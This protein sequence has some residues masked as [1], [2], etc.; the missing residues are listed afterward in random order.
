MTA[1]TNSNQALGANPV[2][3]LLDLPDE[4]VHAALAS[5]DWDLT[6]ART[7][8][9]THGVHSYPAKF[10]PQLPARIIGALSEPGDLVVDPFA[11]GGTTGVEAM[12]LGRRFVGVDANPV[13][14]LL[15]NVKTTPLTRFDLDEVEAIAADATALVHKQLRRRGDQVPA[16]PNLE[17][18]Y[19]PQVVTCLSMLR[20]L[21]S[22]TPEGAARN[23]AFAAFANT[24]ARMSYQESETRYVSKPRHIDGRAPIHSFTA[25]LDRMVAR[26]RSLDGLPADGLNF[27]VGDARQREDFPLSCGSAGLV[28]TSPPYPNAYDYHLYH[29]F[30]IF[31][32]GADPKNLRRVE[33]GS[34]LKHQTDVD[35]PA[36]Y[37]AD[38]A[39]VLE[40]VHE[41]LQPGRYA[42]FVV[43]DGIYKGETYR[44]AERLSEIAISHGWKALSPITRR[45]PATRRAVTAAGRRLQT[46]EIVLLR[47]PTRPTWALPIE[48]NYKRFPYELDLARRELLALTGMDLAG[49]HTPD[50]SEAAVSGLTAAVAQSAFWHGID[51]DGLGPTAT[52]QRLLEDPTGGKRKNSTYATHGLHRYKGKF[53]P[54]LA[55]ALINLSSI[56]HPSPLLLDPFGGSGTVMLESVLSGRDAWSIDCSPLATAVAQTKVDILQVPP[57]ELM[58][59]VQAWID[60]LTTLDARAAIEWNQFKEATHDELESWFAPAVLAKLS[61]LLKSLREA[62]DTR[63]IAFGEVLVSDLIR[64]V[65]HQDPRD[66][67]IRRRSDPLDDA[68]VLELFIERLKSASFKIAAYHSI[69]STL[70]PPLGSGR[71]VLGTSASSDAY[72]ELNRRIDCVVSSP[73]YATALPYIDTDRLSLAAVYGYDKGARKFLEQR[74]IG[75]RE[76]TRA[77]Q[78]EMEELIRTG[79]TDELPPSTASFL[80]ELLDA[81]QRDN[82]AGFRK[83]QLPTVLTKYFRG[84]SAVLSQMRPHLMPGA[85][86][87]FVLGDSRTTIGGRKWTVPTVEEFQSI[88]KHA[89]LDLIE[90]IPITVTRENV[91]HAHNTITEN[92]VVHL[93]TPLSGESKYRPLSSP[94]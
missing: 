7:D 88:A 43:G 50:V 69:G 6:T 15:G 93:Q 42:V 73:P 14:I 32:L 62:H 79:L 49:E 89:G 65:S 80:Q 33:I 83:Q 25:E 44:T 24:A 41:I 27:R 5:L 34:H 46:E 22:A 31:W 48:P 94:T 72:K 26:V 10:I 13:A 60:R 86:L 29:R 16:I 78:R 82:S 81:T 19:A 87:W 36:A 92:A 1:N 76:T 66:L 11:G 59:Q 28:V 51:I 3:S 17:K 37:E 63:I 56:E 71:A 90:K 40:N 85:H 91:I 20:A 8:A 23:I 30:R 70:R 75:S 67:R 77:E 2:P 53:Y 9:L 57:G 84:I 74:L 52:T 4:D 12:R 39:S 47:K 68:P 45:L 21:I 55:K 54:Q 61:F 35:P 18:W 38:M 58:T 64:E